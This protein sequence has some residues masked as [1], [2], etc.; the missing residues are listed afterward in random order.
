MDSFGLLIS[1]VYVPAR[2]F[3]PSPERAAQLFGGHHQE[4]GMIWHVAGTRS[5]K[6]IGGPVIRGLHLWAILGSNQ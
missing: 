2:A 6:R 3:M 5:W 1:R 4:K